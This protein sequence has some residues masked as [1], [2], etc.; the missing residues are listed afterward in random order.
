MCPYCGATLKREQ[1]WCP[2]CERHLTGSGGKVEDEFD[3]LKYD[4]KLVQK[5]GPLPEEELKTKS[6]MLFVLLIGVLVVLG[7][8]L[9]LAITLI[10]ASQEPKYVGPYGFVIFID[11]R[12][13]LCRMSSGLHRLQCLEL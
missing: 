10:K 9:A 6:K 8:G 1:F 7:V 3:G 4:S 12:E 13:T 2:E 11:R 5:T